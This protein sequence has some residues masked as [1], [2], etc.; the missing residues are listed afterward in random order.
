MFR[1][2]ARNAAEPRLEP[3]VLAGE[4][5]CERG[6]RALRH[7]RERATGRPRMQ[8]VARL[9]WRPRQRRAQVELLEM[10]F[11]VITM[12]E[13]NIVNLER[14]GFNL[15]NFDMTVVFKA[16]GAG[17][18]RRGPP[19][20]RRPAPLVLLPR[21]ACPRAHRAPCPRGGLP[22]AAAWLAAY[23]TA[24]MQGGGARVLVLGTRR[25]SCASPDCSWAHACARRHE[26]P[27]RAGPD[28]GRGA[29][30]RHPVHVPGHDPGAA[31]ARVVGPAD[32]P[33]YHCS[34]FC[35]TLTPCTRMCSKFLGYSLCEGSGVH[36]GVCACEAHQR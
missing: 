11:T 6:A 15:R 10:P 20:G 12:A 9:G 1:A 7:G 17:R 27:R 5:G 28:P 14:V 23:W 26:V 31:P 29:H 36:S 2:P 19:P 8:G 30:R 33:A 21:P 18:P 25:P 22:R 34:P 32:R 13:V 35:G 24:C 3:T 4:A 16:R